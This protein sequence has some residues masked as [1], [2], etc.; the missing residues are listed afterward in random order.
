MDTQKALQD[1]IITWDTQLA[2]VGCCLHI[3]KTNKKSPESSLLPV[4]ESETAQTHN[5]AFVQRI[6]VVVFQFVLAWR[7]FLKIAERGSR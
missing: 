4:W 6:S 7:E 3:L 5:D 1:R 2:P